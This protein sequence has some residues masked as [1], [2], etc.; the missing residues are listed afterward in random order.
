MFWVP[1]NTSCMTDR[2][3]CVFMRLCVGEQGWHMQRHTKA[4]WVL[5]VVLD[6]VGGRP[7]RS[8]DLLLSCGVGF[9]AVRGSRHQP[10]LRVF[11]SC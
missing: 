3:Q 9:K 4:C 10:L 1:G 11:H 5:V 8:S 6:P 2:C 7:R